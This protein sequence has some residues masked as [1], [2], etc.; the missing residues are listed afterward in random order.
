MRIVLGLLLVALGFGVTYL[1]VLGFVPIALVGL[2][3]LI[4]LWPVLH[5]PGVGSSGWS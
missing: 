4:L 5:L 3:A 1:G 2:G